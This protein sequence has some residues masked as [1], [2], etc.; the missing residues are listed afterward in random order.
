RVPAVRLVVV[1]RRQVHEQRPLVRVTERVTAQ[2]LAADDLLVD[3]AGQIR[4]PGQHD[5]SLAELVRDLQVTEDSRSDRTGCLVR[6]QLRGA[7]DDPEPGVR[8]AGRGHR[9]LPG[10][11]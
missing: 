1:P 4:G 8:D 10:R 5:S 9:A 11:W 7:V 2:Q 3:A 6:S